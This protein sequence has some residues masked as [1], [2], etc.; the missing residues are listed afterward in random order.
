MIHAMIEYEEDE[1]PMMAMLKGVNDE[2]NRVT[3]AD[4]AVWFTSRHPTVVDVIPRSSESGLYEGGHM[5]VDIQRFLEELRHEPA[6]AG[7]DGILRAAQR[8]N[9]APEK[10]TRQ[11]K[12]P[13]KGGQYGLQHYAD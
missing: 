7:V 3:Q 4:V 1:E 2:L 12:K 5:A 11:K 6:G 10:P 9:P 13:T 8:V